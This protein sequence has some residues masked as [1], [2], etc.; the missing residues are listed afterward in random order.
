MSALSIRPAQRAD[1]AAIVAINAAGRPG[2]YP[3]MLDEVDATLASAP[4]VT[5]AELG[6]QVVGYL[7][8][9]TAGD[10][11]EGEEFAWFQAHVSRFLYIDQ[12]AVAPAARRAHVGARLYA[13]AAA[14]ALAHDLS[15]LVCEVNLDPPNPAS[16]RFHER[17]G[18]QEIGVISVQDGRTVSL[19]R[20]N[21]AVSDHYG[22]WRSLAVAV[23][24]GHGIHAC[25]N[26]P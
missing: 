22:T 25:R 16:L 5:V 24:Q 4:Y 2:V 1:A 14:H 23:C 18:F 9:Y 11:C 6:G 8:G 12:V 15:A 19:R 20:K 26:V 21:L 17:L 7:I 10:V 13:H 3:L